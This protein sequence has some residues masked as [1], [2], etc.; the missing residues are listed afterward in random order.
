MEWE[1]AESFD[2]KVW[3]GYVLGDHWFSVIGGEIINYNAPKS[4]G[5]PRIKEDRTDD[6]AKRECQY[7]LDRWLA[8]VLEEN[9]REPAPVVAPEIVDLGWANGWKT[10]PD[11]IGKC[12]GARLDGEPHEYTR[13]KTKR[14]IH[15]MTCKTC[16]YTYQEDSG[17]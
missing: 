8:K 3:R 9:R 11:I 15:T 7:M 1:L 13:T 2:G 5:D 14:G 6:E 10:A 16:K 12:L 4:I 17:D